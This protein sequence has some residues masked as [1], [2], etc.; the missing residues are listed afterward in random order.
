MDGGRIPWNATGL[1]IGVDKKINQ[2]TA[3][4][5]EHSDSLDNR[6]PRGV[7]WV[8]LRYY[9]KSIFFIRNL[10]FFDKDNNVNVSFNSGQLLRECWSAISETILI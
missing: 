4:K 9:Q 2:L 1:C 3:R 10:R 6:P 8:M 7:S 5:D